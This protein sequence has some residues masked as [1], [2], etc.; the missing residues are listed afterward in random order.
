MI[1]LLFDEKVFVGDNMW[2]KWIIS[3]IV[4]CVLEILVPGFVICFFGVAAIITGIL[5]YIFP[6]ISLPWLFLIFSALSIVLTLV[7]RR[8]IPKVFKGETEKANANSDC[9]DFSHA[10]AVVVEEIKP[11][12]VGGKVSFEGSFWTARSDEEILAGEEVHVIKRENITL[13]VE[14]I[15]K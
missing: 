6:N 2:E 10:T 14:K 8:F 9:D 15:K 4:L 3:G 11:G 12:I 13:I 5:S 1:V 7:L